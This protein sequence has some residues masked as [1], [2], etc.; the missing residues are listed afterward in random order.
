MGWPGPIYDLIMQLSWISSKSQRG[1]N[2]LFLT[3][4]ALLVSFAHAEEIFNEENNTYELDKN[5]FWKIALKNDKHVVIEL[6]TS[7]T[8]C[9]K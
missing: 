7:A 5:N 6:Y 1:V 9:G 4:Y 2:M 3:L 8:W